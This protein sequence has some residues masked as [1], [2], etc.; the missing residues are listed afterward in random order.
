MNID[1]KGDCIE[2]P[3]LFYKRQVG[4]DDRHDVGSIKYLLYKNGLN[5]VNIIDEVDTGGVRLTCAS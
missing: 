4:V 2:E 5:F 1:R 3:R